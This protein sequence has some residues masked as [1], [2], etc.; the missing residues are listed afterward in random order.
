MVMDLPTNL[1]DGLISPATVSSTEE[2]KE[3]HVSA[4]EAPKEDGIIEDGCR[5]EGPEKMLEVDFV[6]GVG[7]SGGLRALSRPVL[8]GILSL[9]RC[10]I[11]SSSHNEHYDA[12]VL[13]ESSLFVAEYKM[14]LKTCGTTTLL[15]CLPL[16]LEATKK[17]GMVLEWLGYSRKNFTFP[18]D[19]TFPHCSFTQEI[20]YAK[21]C[22]G[23]LGEQLMGGAYMLGDLLKD[24]FYVYVADYCERDCKESIDRNINIMMY[25]LD[26]EVQATFYKKDKCPRSD[27]LRARKESKIA[28]LI[29]DAS[30]DDYMYEPCG[31][32]MNALENDAFYTVHVTPENK[33][34]YASFETNLQASCYRKLVEGVLD[35]FKPKRFTLSVFADAAAF[36]TMEI[37]PAYWHSVGQYK[38]VSRSSTCFKVDYV[39]QLANFVASDTAVVDSTIDEMPFL[40]EETDL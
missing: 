16:L 33:F 39:C 10:Q 6:P 14:F 38:R 40:Y 28:Q 18:S 17:N 15:R 21:R 11:L 4:M 34:S 24:H 31:Y 26:P 12:Y 19:Q 3:A 36:K 1:D 32:S 35:T 23:P 9:A 20:E 37:S 27:A 5:F 29:R 8:E 7:A 25:D 30:I 22:V 2:G 13:S